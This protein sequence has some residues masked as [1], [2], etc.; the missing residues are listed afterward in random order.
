LLGS[1][2]HI[3]KRYMPTETAGEGNL[4]RLVI[5]ITIK[6]GE[7]DFNHIAIFI[8]RWICLIGHKGGTGMDS[9]F[10]VQVCGIDA[11]GG[12]NRQFRTDICGGESILSTRAASMD[13]G[14]SKRIGPA[15]QGGG[16]G[17]ITLLHSDADAGTGNRFAPSINMGNDGCAEI[18]F[19]C[20]LEKGVPVPLVIFTKGE[21][22]SNDNF[23]QGG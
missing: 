7:M 16:Q 1:G 18:E 21:V 8:L 2:I 14:S 19:W 11:R 17:E 22:K 23:N 13:D 3:R 10:Q 6:L 4:D 5:D 12:P 20:E 9:V 15:Q